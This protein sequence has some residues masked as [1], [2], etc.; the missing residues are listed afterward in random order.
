MHRYPAKTFNISLS[1]PIDAISIKQA[2]TTTTARI[3]TT[4]GAMFVFVCI[5]K[6]KKYAFV[7][8]VAD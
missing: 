4:L 6:F 3:K 1:T 8:F 2:G 5:I 7:L